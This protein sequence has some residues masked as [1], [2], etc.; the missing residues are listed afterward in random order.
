MLQMEK[1]YMDGKA[2]FAVEGRLDAVS[3]PQ[4]E[5]ELQTLPEDVTELVLDFEKLE[6]ISSAGL[7]AVLAAQKRMNRQ[8]SMRVVNVGEAVKAVFDITG[9]STI[10]T[11]D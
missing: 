10:L 8:G 5:Q 3:G 2:V 9:F 1:E 6:Y 4:F 7:R 11:I